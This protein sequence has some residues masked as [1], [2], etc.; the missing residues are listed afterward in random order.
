MQMIRHPAVRQDA[1]PEAGCH[2]A[3]QGIQVGTVAIRAKQR[4]LVIAP[5]NDVI[6]AAGHVQTRF[7]GHPFLR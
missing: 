3:N 5:Q 6:E 1:Q 7:A 4:F 2:V